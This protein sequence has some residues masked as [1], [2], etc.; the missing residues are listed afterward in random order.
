MNGGPH[1]QSQIAF[2][3]RKRRGILCALQGNHAARL[4]AILRRCILT[5]FVDVV[6]D[7]EAGSVSVC[8]FFPFY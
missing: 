3:L 7:P 1:V 2:Q 6:G 8:F 5:S 4:W